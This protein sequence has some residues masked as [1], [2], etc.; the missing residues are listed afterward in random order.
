M[1]YASSRGRLGTIELLRTRN[2]TTWSDCA[3]FA[4]LPMISKECCKLGEHHCHLGHH[5]WQLPSAT[6][7]KRHK[8]QVQLPPSKV[9]RPDHVEL[10]PATINPDKD[11]VQRPS[12]EIK[13]SKLNV[14]KTHYKPYRT[15]MPPLRETRQAPV[16]R[17]SPLLV[18]I[19]Q[20]R[21]QMR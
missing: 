19:A 21:I 8:E 1:V 6:I 17:L 2:V 12:S 9:Q 3:S 7:H 4:V 14:S 16:R 11:Q 20:V 15:S 5:P 10:Q 18:W 13:Q